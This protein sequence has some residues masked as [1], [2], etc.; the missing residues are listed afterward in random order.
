MTNID[1]LKN[2]PLLDMEQW[3]WIFAVHE[4]PPYDYADLGAIATRL[5]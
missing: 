2:V 3:V 4:H 1:L 5:R